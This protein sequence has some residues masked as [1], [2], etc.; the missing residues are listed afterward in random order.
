VVIPLICRESIGTNLPEN[1]ITLSLHSSFAEI[2][3]D[4]LELQKNGLGTFYQSFEWCKAWHE[5]AGKIRGI[6]PA[7]LCGR[8]DDGQLVFILPFAIEKQLGFKVLRW[9]SA[10]EITYGMGVFDRQ[11]LA[12]HPDQLKLLWPDILKMLGTVDTIK[13]E[14]QPKI[15]DG[16]ENPLQFLFTTRAANQSFKM[17]IHD[18]FQALYEQKRS[19][20][21][22]RGARKRDKKLLAVGEV[23][24]GLPD[25]LDETARVI[26]I[27]LHQ[28]RRRLGEKG[29]RSV[30]SDTRQA[31]LQRLAKSTA[32]DGSP[33][34]LPYHLTIDGKIAAVM[35]GGT[36][37]SSYWALISSLTTDSR[38]HVLSPG[39]HTLRAM[40]KA[41]CQKSYRTID[42]AAGDT[43][44]KSHWSDE[45][46]PLYETIKA[47]TIKGTIWT[48][49]AFV[50]TLTKR[51]IKQT[52]WMFSIAQATR[53]ALFK[54][55]KK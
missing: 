43:D 19:A 5:T 54:P 8:L 22:R 40:I 49:Y 35:L 27:M 47:Q 23:S 33:I 20:S 12:E 18:N 37:Q 45:I 13:L 16:I 7:I 24:F 3:D 52:P 14:S 10:Q 30:Y 28:Q 42:F 41:L 17:A 55:A 46:I 25:G 44:Y 31:F 48:G 51:I 39:D 36:F 2:E 9:Y 4:W 1:S 50:R 32:L 15:W 38:L 21:S 53:K 34:L 11:W 6:E 26:D 29:I